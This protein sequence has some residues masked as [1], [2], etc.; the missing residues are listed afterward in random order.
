MLSADTLEKWWR[1]DR[2]TRFLVRIERG[3]STDFV[4]DGIAAALGDT[5]S[6]KVL[7]VSDLLDY[8]R[9][10]LYAAFGAVDV[11]YTV[12]LVPTGVG[13]LLFLFTNFHDRRRDLARLVG[14]GVTR[15]ELVTAV[16][17][18]LIVVVVAGLALGL[19]GGAVSGSLWVN[20]HLAYLLGWVLDFGFPWAI[21]ARGAATVVAV[22]A[23]ALVLPL[24]QL[25]GLDVA[26]MTAEDA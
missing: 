15:R 8:H 18:E 26:A 23:A 11:L 10:R 12:L 1:D 3:V 16:V 17:L 9:G 6:Y 25:R 19:A 4:R 14:L 21:C 5:A 7:S 2:V 22:C 13:I 24:W 20:F